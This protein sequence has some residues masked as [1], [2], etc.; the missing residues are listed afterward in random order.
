MSK[1]LNTKT[2]LQQKRTHCDRNV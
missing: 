1:E 2:K